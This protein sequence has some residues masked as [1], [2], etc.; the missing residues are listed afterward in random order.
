MELEAVSGSAL[1]TLRKEIH[2]LPIAMSQ[3]RLLNLLLRLTFMAETLPFTK[4]ESESES[5]LAAWA[6]KTR[7]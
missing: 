3:S 1:E 4:Y 7:C 6:M 5:F 2:A